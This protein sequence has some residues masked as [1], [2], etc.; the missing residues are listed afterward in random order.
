M[1]DAEVRE[2]IEAK[3][4]AVEG[5]YASGEVDKLAETFAHDVWQMPPDSPPLVGRE[6]L[7]EFWSQAVQ[8]G[9]WK[10]S[11][12]TQDVVVNVPIA[13]ERGKYELEFIAGPEA[14]PDMH[15]F[16]DRGNYVVLWR[17]DEDGEW[18]ILWDAPVSELPASTATDVA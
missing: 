9:D 11:L 15:S 16:E 4:Q 2:I 7:R 5:W 18:R 10:F 8:A 6:A 17:R 14:P 3:N 1:D 12:S 13:V